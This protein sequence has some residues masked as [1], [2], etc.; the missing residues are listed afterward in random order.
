MREDFNLN[1]CYCI[2]VSDFDFGKA[3]KIVKISRNYYMLEIDKDCDSTFVCLG[4]IEGKEKWGFR[5][6]LMGMTRVSNNAVLDKEFLLNIGFIEK[7]QRLLKKHKY[8]LK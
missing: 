5:T 2:I 8:I 6:I 3:K 4:K 1:R 7:A